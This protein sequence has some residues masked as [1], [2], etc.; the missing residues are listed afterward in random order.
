MHESD[1][2]REQ[3]RVSLSAHTHTHTHTL[4]HIYHQHPS[5]GL[6]LCSGVG[7]LSSSQ[8]AVVPG[9]YSC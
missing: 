8:G 9:I 3:S 1:T 4:E 2:A 6:I 7:A 5:M